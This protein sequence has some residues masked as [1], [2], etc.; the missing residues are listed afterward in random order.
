MTGGRFAPSP[1]GPLHL[2]SLLAATA[3]FLD[4]RSSGGTWRLRLDD[5]DTPRNQPG[6]ETLILHA[7]EAHGLHWDGGIQRQSE[8]LDQ[9]LHALETLAERCFYCRCSRR[10]LAGQLIYPGTCRHHIR[11]RADA[12]IRI[13]VDAKPIRFNDLLMGLQQ[14]VLSESLGDFIIR[15]RDGLIAYQL[16]TA[17]DDGAADIKRVVRGSDLLD[18]TAR[19]IFLMQQLDLDIPEYAHIPT[20]VYPSGQK[21]SKQHGA[22]GVDNSVAT[23]NLAL[24]LQAL[25]MNLPPDLSDSQ[26]EELLSWATGVWQLDNLPRTDQ[27]LET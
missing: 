6:A 21:L 20:L 2:G 1:T 3:S 25:N 12:A 5:L 11:P 17:V 16:A 19:Q 22:P 14:E 9:Y 27:V 8:H 4:A 10:S 13:R 7:L 26:P 24:V 23:Q 18:N 15:R